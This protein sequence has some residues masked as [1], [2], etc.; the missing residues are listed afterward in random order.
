MNKLREPK[1]EYGALLRKK[2][3]ELGLSQ[4]EVAK[5]LG[6]TQQGFSR[7][8]IG[9]RRITLSD[10]VRFSKKYAPDMIKFLLVLPIFFDILC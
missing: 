1:D 3:L 5:E 4:E 2:R 10:F 8:E 7:K 9:D 6:M